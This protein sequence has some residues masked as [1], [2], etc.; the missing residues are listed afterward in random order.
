MALS[1]LASVI[2]HNRHIGHIAIDAGA[3]A[4]SKDISANANWPQVG[5]GSICHPETMAPLNDLHVARVSQEHGVIPVTDDGTYERLPIGSKVRVLP[6]HACITAAGYDC[7]YVIEGTQV[8][9]EWDRVN[10]W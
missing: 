7:Y 3:L 6:N 9:D 1:V 10:G 2:G 4:L 5:Y 8:V